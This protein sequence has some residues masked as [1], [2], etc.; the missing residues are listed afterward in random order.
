MPVVGVR[1]NLS[2]EL[3][4]SGGE[5]L[6]L[7]K[8]LLDFLDALAA[9]LGA[10]EAAFVVVIRAEDL[11]SEAGEF[12]G[13]RA[14][15]VEIDQTAEIRV[16]MRGVDLHGKVEEVYGLVDSVITAADFLAGDLAGFGHLA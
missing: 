3:L 13:F 4:A 11:V 8:P 2:N 12:G 7:F 15:L 5:R 10:G 14:V 16:G 9:I 6:F 1:R